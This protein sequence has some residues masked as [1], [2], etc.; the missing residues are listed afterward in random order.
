MTGYSLTKIFKPRIEKRK[1]EIGKRKEDKRN[2]PARL[3]WAKAM[4]SGDEHE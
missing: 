3:V 2:H 1:E 4:A